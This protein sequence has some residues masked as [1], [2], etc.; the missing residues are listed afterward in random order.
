ML[1]IH[2]WISGYTNDANLILDTYGWRGASGSSVFDEK[3]RLLGV[4]S[5]MDVGTWA[6]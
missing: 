4:L 3:G 1:T 2:G 6:C 5:A